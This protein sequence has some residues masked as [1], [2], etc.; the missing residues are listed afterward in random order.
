MQKIALPGKLLYYEHL[1][2]A[3]LWAYNIAIKKFDNYRLSS[4]DTKAKNKTTQT[5]HLKIN[6]PNPKLKSLFSNQFLSLYASSQWWYQHLSSSI[7][8]KTKRHLYHLPCPH[9]THQ[10]TPAL[11]IL[12]PKY[13]CDGFPPDYAAYT[14]S[15]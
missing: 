13:I 2:Y 8:Y 11:S 12:S 14:S 7:I 15:K 5:P 4:E 6:M 3:S 9:P 1:L 10:T